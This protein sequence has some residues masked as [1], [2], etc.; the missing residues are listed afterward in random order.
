[1]MISTVSSF[2][3]SMATARVAP[4]SKNHDTQRNGIKLGILLSTIFELKDPISEEITG[5]LDRK[6]E[7]QSTI[8][9][10]KGVLQKKMEEVKRVRKDLPDFEVLD[11]TI[12]S[13]D[14]LDYTTTHLG[15]LGNVY[16]WLKEMGCDE[17]HI[18]SAKEVLR[19]HKVHYPV[20]AKASIEQTARQIEDT[21]NNALVPLGFVMPQKPRV[22]KA[23]NKLPWTQWNVKRPAPPELTLSSSPSSPHYKTNA[24]LI[25]QVADAFYHKYGLEESISELEDDIKMPKEFAYKMSP[26]LWLEE[27]EGNYT[28]NEKHLLNPAILKMVDKIDSLIRRKDA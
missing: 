6:F 12:F 5:D 13:Q 20:P 22:A 19:K 8:V 23:K 14:G 11:Q 2:S 28:P 4:P 3:P 10:L 1:M 15:V 9:R 26:Q 18:K 16:S 7:I 25:Q 27:G 24:L 17:E 21:L